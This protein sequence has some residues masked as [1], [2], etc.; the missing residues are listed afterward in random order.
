MTCR[1]SPRPTTW[2]QLFPARGRGRTALARAWA[3]F[4][5]RNRWYAGRTHTIRSTEILDAVPVAVGRGKPAAFITLV[6]VEYSDGEPETYVVPI[7]AAT[8]PDAVRLPADHPHA[9]VAWVE[10]RSWEERALL[11]DA[12]VDDA[13]MEAAL[14]AFGRNRSFDSLAG[15]ELRT[16]TSPELRR[17][18]SESDDLTVSHPSV[19]QSNTSAVFGHQVVMKIFRRAQEGVNPDLELGRRL[20]EV[21]FEHSARLIGAVEYQRGRAEPRT[22][23]VLTGYVPNEGDAWHYTLDV[24]GLFYEQALGQLPDDQIDIPT[25]AEIPELVGFEPPDTTADAIGPFLDLAEVLGRR[26]AE[27]HHALSDSLTEEF[28]PEPFTT[29]YQ[30]SVYQSM[31]AQVRPTLAM[32]RRLV[33]PAD[34]HEQAVAD[35]VTSSEASILER[36]GAIRQHRID[37]SR[38]RVHGDFHLGQVLHAG[39]DFV[40]IDFEG[41]PSRSPTERR[42]KRSALVDVAG[43]VRSFQY[44]TEAALRGHAERNRLPDPVLSALAYRSRA[45]LAWVTIRFLTG[46]LEEA[47][48]QP[49]VPADADDRH[50]LLTVY[51]LDKALY[52]VRYD[53]SHRPDWAAIPLRGIAE[54]L[55]APDRG[56]RPVTA[57]ASPGIDELYRH[58]SALG[59]DRGYWDVS[60]N[61]NEPGPETVLAVL[62]ALGAPI[63]VASASAS[64]AGMA[65]AIDRLGHHVDE[66][67]LAPLA[68]VVTVLEGQPVRVEVV[69]V[70]PGEGGRVRFEL[71]AED[72]TQRAHEADLAAC[73]LVAG[74]RLDG[75]DW[76]RRAVELPGE[77]LPVGYHELEVE[78]AGARHRAT[79]LVAPAHVHQPGDSDRLWGAFAPLY[80]LRTEQGW[81]PNVFDLDR[82]GA[83]IDSQGGKVVGT[84]PLLASPRSDPSPYTPLSRRFWNEAYL[85]VAE[86]AEWAGSP[87]ARAWLADPDTQRRAERLRSSPTADVGAQGQLVDHVLDEL[88]PAFFAPDHSGDP[89]FARWVDDNP[90]VVD[91]ARFRAVAERHGARWQAWPDALARGTVGAGDYDVA[92]AARHVYAQWSMDSQLA[93]VS[94][95]LAERGQHLYLDL[96]VGCSP[97][98]FDTWIDRHAYGWGA[99]V[100]APPDAF[101]AAGQN[102]GFPPVRPAVARA[103][104]HR[105]LAE[106]LRHHMAYAGMVRL[107]HVMG[108]HRLFWVPEGMDATAGTYV[109]YPTHEQF[110]VVAIE[111]SRAGC[112]VVGEDLGTVPDEVREAMDRHRVLRSY[113]T[114]FSLPSGPDEPLVGPDRRMVATVDTHDTPT[115]AAFVADPDRRRQVESALGRAGWSERLD[116]D[117]SELSLLR[118]SL[119]VLGDSDVPAVLVALDDLVARTEPQ[120]VPGT[121]AERDN[122]VLRLPVTL[123][124]LGADPAVAELLA[125][126]QAHRL[127]SHLRARSAA[128]PGAGQP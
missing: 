23:G 118:A 51:V 83:W 44:A 97:D 70:G 28:R 96:P 90:L 60:G 124:E 17:M 58:A 53:L 123:D 9:A 42:I 115:F 6:Q 109:R 22:L 80:S 63:D 29:L 84:L 86:L 61:W 72:G 57:V 66:Q 120:N 100:G 102:W 30:R 3:P 104:G 19:E 47:E 119:E 18:L 111:S 21:G 122:W 52:E 89:T 108:L 67:A 24:L 25:W 113:V 78:L 39:R 116:S 1:W 79:V 87:R 68:P 2:R 20:S 107:D 71:L 127:A 41:E 92:V 64:E 82:L 65:M 105:L 27:L 75:R 14:R 56:E 16:T 98:G 81:G 125:S 76:Q 37:V 91:Y 48:G 110:A 11:F 73:D 49:F 50:A 128:D 15:A 5:A 10:V 46:Y 114:E 126:V 13:F 55:D 35:L 94:G 95:A 88:A 117:Q 106:C 7:T 112:L 33:Q 99:A 77:P 12:T 54:L 62:G 40:I 101:F 69:H 59:V 26:T 4:F 31:R 32:V 121:G 74:G 34:D 103:E 38:I 36:F 43:M 93:R 45:W 85:D 8:G